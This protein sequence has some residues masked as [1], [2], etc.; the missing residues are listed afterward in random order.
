MK[1][2][3]ILCRDGG[4]PTQADLYDADPL[5]MPRDTRAWAG[6]AS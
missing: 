2:S 6:S 1:S 5:P 4:Q 3:W